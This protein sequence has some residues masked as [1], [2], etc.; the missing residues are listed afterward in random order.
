MMP[1]EL[2]YAQELH[3]AFYERTSPS[4]Y[5][6]I[7]L[8]GGP[9]GVANWLPNEPQS[10]HDCALYKRQPGSGTVFGWSSANCDEHHNFICEIS[11]YVFNQR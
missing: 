2:M 10:Q 1:I 4:L 6:K 7:M 5:Y 9:V 3:I 11:K 8:T